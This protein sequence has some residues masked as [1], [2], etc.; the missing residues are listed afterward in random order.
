MVATVRTPLAVSLTDGPLG[1]L[2]RQ[3]M[4]LLPSLRRPAGVTAA[5]MVSVLAEP[6]VVAAALAARAAG[7]LAG[8]GRSGRPADTRRP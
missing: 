2:D 3:A 6:G 5:R 7:A 4:A 8:Q 1:R